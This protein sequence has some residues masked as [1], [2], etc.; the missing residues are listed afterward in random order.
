MIP[1]E[2]SRLKYQDGN[3]DAGVPKGRELDLRVEGDN[4]DSFAA[5]NVIREN[6]NQGI[7]IVEGSSAAIVGNKIYRN[8]KANIEGHFKHL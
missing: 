8:K 7:L 2:D 4:L 3:F 5:P 1:H 6:S